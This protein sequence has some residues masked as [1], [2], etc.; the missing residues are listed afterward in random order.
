MPEVRRH[1]KIKYHINRG[2]WLKRTGHCS[3]W[4]RCWLESGFHE[5]Q[6]LGGPEMRRKL[7]WCTPTK[8]F[9]RYLFLG[10]HLRRSRSEPIKQVVGGSHRR[11]NPKAISLGS[12]WGVRPSPLRKRS[13]LNREGSG[14]TRSSCNIALLR[15]IKSI[16][17]FKN[18][19][20]H[21]FAMTVLFAGIVYAPYK[22]S[23]E[24]RCGTPKIVHPAVSLLDNVSGNDG[25]IPTGVEAPHLWVICKHSYDERYKFKRT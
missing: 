23:W 19:S 24:T 1:H 21:W 6:A 3:P 2:H 16:Q 14:Y 22:S 15:H 7:M 13:G 5:Y 11:P 25:D 12:F 4:A 10:R 20:Y 8:Y 17:L 18:N 9:L